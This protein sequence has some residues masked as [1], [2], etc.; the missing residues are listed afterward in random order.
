[1]GLAAALIGFGEEVDLISRFHFG[2]PDMQNISRHRARKA[3]LLFS[4]IVLLY[5]LANP[6][7]AE[8]L[9]DI[10]LS[11]D[12]SG[13]VEAT[14]RFS[15]PVQYLR[16]FPQRKSPSLSIYFNV[17]GSTPREKWQNY[18][19]HRSPPSDI[20][21]GFTV[22]TRD[23]STGPK[24]L[25]QFNRPA[26]FS[27]S[28]GKDDRSILI[29]IK[30]DRPQQK[31]EP[32]A[33]RPAE[34]TV[35]PIPIIPP[36]AIP[37]TPVLPPVAAVPA[38]PAVVASKPAVAAAAPAVPVPPVPTLTPPAPS[39]APAEPVAPVAPAIP[40]V[41]AAPK[42]A[43]APRQVVVPKPSVQLGGKEG[44]P[45]F[46]KI[47]P[48]A[49]PPKGGTLPEAV[50]PEQQLQ[51]SNDQAAPLMVAGRDA[52]LSGQMFAA[53]EAF[54][55]VLNLPPNKYS[56]DAQLW[57]GIAREKSG[58][59][60]KARSEY[61]LYLK[62]Y[63]N[64]PETEWVKDRMLRLT[65]A[66]PVAK[67]P[68]AVKPQATE[69]KSAQY[70]SVAMYYYHGASQ[71]D[72]VVT[73]GTTTT[74]V[75]LTAVDQSSLVSNV[76][77]TART[78]NNEYDHRMVFQGLY[79]MNFLEGHDA[80]ER[81]NAAYYEIRSRVDNYSSRIGVQSALGGGVMGRFL[82]VSGGY[83]F[84]QNWRVNAA[85]GQLTE[86]SLNDK[87]TFL[88]GGLDFGLN[89]PLGGSLYY[90]TQKANGLVDRKATG[91]N[92]R[93][94]EQGMTGM[95]MLDYDIQ[96]KEVNMFSLQGSLNRDDGIDLNFML[97]RRRSPSWSVQ[98][99]VSGTSST[100]DILQQNGWT[101][102][103]IL[104]LA[105]LRTP[106]SNMAQ[107]GMTQ[108]I[109][110]KWQ[111]ATDLSASNTTGLPESGTLLGDG[112]IG[113]EGYVPASPS[114][115]TYWTI[116][117]RVS[118][119]NVFTPNDISTASL[120]LS[121]SNTQTGITTMLNSRVLV[122]EPW[123]LDGT[124]RVYWQQD[125]VGGTQLFLTPTFR[126][127]YLLATDLT[128]EGDAGLDWNRTT[129]KDMPKTTTTRLFFSLG[130]RWDF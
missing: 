77:M 113:V 128:L 14:I 37:P 97:D 40:A 53:I 39:L 16:H 92:L 36:V 4:Q 47:D 60:A 31:S 117:E 9:D 81:V 58:Q 104:A 18:E 24:I 1:M 25:V 8:L 89:S 45:L 112:T 126:A 119:T 100:I 129:F 20:V 63:P 105:K 71:T 44:L 50:T 65:A 122:Q 5:S 72:T 42:A 76:N 108:R 111:L 84:L 30:A 106:I 78:F 127:S 107:I 90:I 83:G 21:T 69:F 123:T 33:M 10:A 64:E 19:S 88:S 91:G 75:T 121:K 109:N 95:A 66:L 11:K 79:S 17:L 103:D 3:L 57:M 82:G 99:A 101:M 2:M 114:S 124:M 74:P 86:K 120:S 48:Y 102:E 68:E 46:P 6:A 94:F 51:R 125:N 118:G 93:Y 23:L 43:V 49:L 35:V 62:L 110:E 80:R 28:P 15:V 85:Y 32:E 41:V 67:K 61:E 96:F 70:G 27:V 13:G 130:G 38:E 52:L 73:N 26:E 34:K 115:G 12:A 54:N 56:A 59:Q 22:T 55:K 98:N 29:H 87:P 7:R 116:S